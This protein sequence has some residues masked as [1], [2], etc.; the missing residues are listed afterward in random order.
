M[1]DLFSQCT[2]VHKCQSCLGILIV[3]SGF[4][5]SCLSFIA[6]EVGTLEIGAR[7]CWAFRD[8]YQTLIANHYIVSFTFSHPPTHTTHTHTTHTHPHPHP[9]IPTH[10][11]THTYKATLHMKL[12][13]EDSRTQQHI[14]SSTLLTHVPKTSGASTRPMTTPT[15]SVTPLRTS[16]TPS[17]PRSFR[18]SE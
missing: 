2:Y 16:H 1:K 17:V 5:A 10:T 9:H 4:P 13:T 8:C 15:V 3:L 14:E 18:S 7:A 11:H 6:Y 12:L